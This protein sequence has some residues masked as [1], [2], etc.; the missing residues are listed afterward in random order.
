MFISNRQ[1]SLRLWETWTDLIREQGSN[2][3]FFL[4]TIDLQEH[5]LLFFVTREHGQLN[6]FGKGNMASKH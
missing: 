1:R 6:F 5:G 4:G 2:S 3:I